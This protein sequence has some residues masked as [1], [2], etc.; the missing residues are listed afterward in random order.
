VTFG[1]F[2]GRGARHF[3]HA[4][5]ASSTRNQVS[6]S[7]FAASPSV[8]SASEGPRPSERVDDSTELSTKIGIDGQGNVV[9][10]HVPGD[11]RGRV[12]ATVA[13]EGHGE[14]EVVIA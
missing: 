6:G 8:T 10:L 4:G 12:V 13:L 14:L 11:D 2:V 7:P 9:Q 5:G 1:I 3:S